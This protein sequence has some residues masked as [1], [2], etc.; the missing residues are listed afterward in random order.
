MTISEDMFGLCQ[1]Q[2]VGESTEKMAQVDRGEALR[3]F[4]GVYTPQT[5]F[6]CLGE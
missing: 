3:A 6:I 4:M 1:F 5:C 2:F